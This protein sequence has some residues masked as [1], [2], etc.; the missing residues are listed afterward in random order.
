MVVAPLAVLAASAAVAA[1]VG[2]DP[3]Q[4]TPTSVVEG[5]RVTVA[6]RCPSVAGRTFV[7]ATIGIDAL[8]RYVVVPV[9]GGAFHGTV[10]V[11]APGS[12]AKP[13]V[14]THLALQVSCRTAAA[15]VARVG[16][17]TL[18]VVRTGTKQHPAAVAAP[19]VRTPAT[20]PVADTG[21]QQI[22][23]GV[24]LAALAIAVTATVGA[25]GLG[26]RARRRDDAMSRHPAY[27]GVGRE[28]RLARR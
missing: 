28:P 24:P 8:N 3:L 22:P 25:Y 26:V 11:L 15:Y 12:S 17:A 10:T 9:T 4:V 16:S 13:R 18:H 14:G 21:E 2:T 19:T 23:L 1:P 20:R 5:H 7:G 27:R 6:G